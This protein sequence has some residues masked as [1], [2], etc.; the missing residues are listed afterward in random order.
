MKK[1]I[2]IVL[3]ALLA[4]PIFSQPEARP[5][6]REISVRKVAAAVG[7][8][9]ANR[10]RTGGG[11]GGPTLLSHAAGVAATAPIDTTGASLIVAC[12][13][14]NGTNFSST[15]SNTWTHV[16][17][18]NAG[19][20]ELNIFYCEAPSTSST[21]TFA[22]SDAF[23]SLA[24][25]AWSGTASNPFDQVNGATQP[26]PVQSG[27]ITPSQANTLVIAFHAGQATS[28][29]IDS[30]YAIT[31]SVSFTGGINYSCAMAYI[32]LT[33]ATAQNPTWTG[34]GMGGGTLS[35]PGIA[36]FKY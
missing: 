12:T 29:A 7:P 19:Q 23:A 32:I 1:L 17:S 14:A 13:S 10:R 15:P 31:D 25:S 5:V 2:C 24:V 11:G 9:A 30:G 20:N 28:Y 18:Y 8:I 33:S 34:S 6:R 16:G 22:C 4:A 27:S 3:C 35:A 36:S 26:V 21:Q